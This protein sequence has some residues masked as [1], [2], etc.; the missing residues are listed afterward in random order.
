MGKIYLDIIKIITYLSSNSRLE[1]L[2]MQLTH[3]TVLFDGKQFGTVVRAKPLQW[4]RGNSLA[5]R[6][7]KHGMHTGHVAEHIQSRHTFRYDSI[8]THSQILN[9]VFAN[10]RLSSRSLDILIA[11]A[12]KKPISSTPR[13]KS[14]MQADVILLIKNQK[15]QVKPTFSN[16]HTRPSALLSELEM[17]GQ[18]SLAM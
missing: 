16:L 14:A 12:P 15:R 1:R 13:P 7:H 6:E 9:P 10:G 3:R 17:R 18:S 8:A 11:L 5:S 4:Y 2:C